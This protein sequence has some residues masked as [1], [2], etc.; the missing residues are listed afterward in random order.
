[1]GNFSQASAEWPLAADFTSKT[2]NITNKRYGGMF[3]VNWVNS[4]SAAGILKFQLSNDEVKWQ[5]WTGLRTT[6]S[7]A[8]NEAPISIGDDS[9]NW[10]VKNW[11]GRYIRL[12]YVAN[13]T[14]TGTASLFIHNSRA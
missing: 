10:E 11:T 4:D 12:V 7:S 3:Q 1:M 9:Q 14:T 2:L 6:D 8:V 13:G 5:D